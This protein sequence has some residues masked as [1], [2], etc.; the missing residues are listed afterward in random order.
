MR[1]LVQNLRLTEI[2]AKMLEAAFLELHEETIKQ[3]FKAYDVIL[4]YMFFLPG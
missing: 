1:K 2:L 4:A 3:N